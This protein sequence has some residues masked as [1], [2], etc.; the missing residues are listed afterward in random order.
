M[1][2]RGPGRQSGNRIMQI[3]IM[4]ECY[5]EAVEK[6]QTKMQGYVRTEK[7]GR[8]TGYHSVL[9]VTELHAGTSADI[10]RHGAER[11][12]PV[13]DNR[14]ECMEHRLVLDG[15][16]QKLVLAAHVRQNE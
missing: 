16:V 3:V 13:L 14:I 5:P 10:H 12:E 6:F 2:I 8:S 15:A 11:S 4:A 9:Y 7:T 1:V